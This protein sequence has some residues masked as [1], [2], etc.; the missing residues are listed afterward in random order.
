MFNQVAARFVNNV[1]VINPDQEIVTWFLDKNTN[2]WAADNGDHGWDLFTM[3]HFYQTHS[4]GL[5]R[6][7]VYEFIAVRYW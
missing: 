5:N 7:I 4:Y 2:E 1:W 3:I 6:G